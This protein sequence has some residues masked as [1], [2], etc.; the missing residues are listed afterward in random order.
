MAETDVLFVGAIAVGIVGVM[1]IQRAIFALATIKYNK[2]W[3][4]CEDEW[5]Q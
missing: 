1:V 3:K 5:Q 2:I 4:D